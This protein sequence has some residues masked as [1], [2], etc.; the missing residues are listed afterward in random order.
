MQV[1]I[2]GSAARLLSVVFLTAVVACVVVP[3]LNR[4]S[5]VRNCRRSPVDEHR[6]TN[7][8]PSPWLLLRANGDF[9]DGL[10]KWFDDRVGFRDLFIRT[11]NQIDYSI[12]STSRKVY[13]GSE[14]WL[15][16]R[17]PG[18]PLERL[19]ANGFDAVTN[20]FLDL[21]RRLSNK[22]IRLV[23]VGYPDKSRVYPE[24]LPADATLLL[25]G[26]NYDKL[27][28]FLS[29]QP[30]LTFIDVEEVLRR[31]KSTT[32]D[33]LYRKTDLHA[34][35][36]GQVA[37]IKEIVARIARAEGRPDIRW[38]ESFEPIT[39]MWGP[40]NEARFLSLLVPVLEN[41][42]SFKGTYKP[43]DNEPDGHWTIPDAQ[44]YQRA[45]DG[46]GPLFAWEFHSL[47]ELCSERLPGTVLLG[48]S[49]VDLYPTLGLHRYFCSFRRLDPL[50]V[51]AAVDRLALF[52]ESVPDGTKYFIYQYYAPSF[53]T[54]RFTI[55]DLAPIS[56]MPGDAV[57]GVQLAT[58]SLRL[59]A[60][61][62]LAVF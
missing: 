62:L 17:D 15:F 60:G 22:G 36:S 50:N 47:P 13:V 21:A 3:L 6:T 5:V 18:L 44:A 37:V 25:P 59:L 31:E 49:F 48:V 12:F 19:D 43:G 53:T 8:F 20:S 23:V 11:K 9:A 46:I 54:C 14:G 40:G 42:R 41:Y 16:K 27:R 26:G 57:D 7:R 34:T 38:N 10:N 35:E 39:G 51:R 58:V 45:D 1:T 24:M 33:T 29:R 4:V 30:T 32:T 56:V 2:G 55:S 61:I 52:L 28:Q